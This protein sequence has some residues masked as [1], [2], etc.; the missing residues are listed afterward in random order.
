MQKSGMTVVK[1]DAAALAEFRTVADG[2][3]KTMR[4][5]LVPR[6]V[7]ELAVRER[8]A[9]R[10]ARPIASDDRRSGRVAAHRLASRPGASS[11]RGRLLAAVALGV[12]VVLPLAEILLRRFAGTGIPGSIPFVQHLVLWVGFLGAALAAR[13][14]T[15]LALATGTFLPL[16]AP[17]TGPIRLPPRSPPRCRRCCASARSSS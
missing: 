17:A 8:D 15:M 7:F 10:K 14:G 12:M 4:D 11:L 16:V 3:T 2:F 9:Y 6:D 13:E 5:G 1:A